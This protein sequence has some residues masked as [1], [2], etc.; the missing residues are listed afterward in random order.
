MEGATA[1]EGTTAM[2]AMDD[3]ARR[4]WMARR[5]LDG[6]GR[7]DSS[8]TVMDDKGRRERNGDGNGRCNDDST[9]MDSGARRQWTEQGQLNGDGRRVGDTT[10][11]DDEEGTSAT[12]MSTRPTMEATKASAASRH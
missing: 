1:M 5:Q 6:K 4:Q 11:M 8:L 7:H 9:V 2:D 3:V 12:A 10:T